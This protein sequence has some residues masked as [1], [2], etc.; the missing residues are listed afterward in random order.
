METARARAAPRSPGRAPVDATSGTRG[1]G[2]PDLA[3]LPRTRHPWQV[4]PASAAPLGGPPPGGRVIEAPPRPRSQ[5]AR[6][7]PGRRGW[8]LAAAAGRTGGGLGLTG[9][10]DH[11]LQMPQV[12]QDRVLR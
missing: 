6:G 12:R 2:A 1:A 10:T 3:R 8:A 7:Q 4:R 9:R 5:W 11:G